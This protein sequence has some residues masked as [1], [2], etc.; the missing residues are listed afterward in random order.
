MNANRSP[1][2]ELRRNLLTVV[3][4]QRRLVVEQIELR[5]RA[6]HEQIDD[7]L[8]LRRK[9]RR[10]RREGPSRGCANSLSSSSADSASPPMPK[11]DC[12]KKCR[13]VMARRIVGCICIPWSPFRRGSTARSRRASRPPARA[14]SMSFDRIALDDTCR[15]GRGRLGTVRAA[16]GMTRRSVRPL[17][18]AGGRV[19]DEPEGER[20][21]ASIEGP[22]PRAATRAASA[23]A[24]SKI[25]FV[26]QAS[27]APAAACSCAR[28]GPCSAR[29]SS[30]RTS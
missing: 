27:S 22:A 30:H 14:A 5:R 9:V 16:A 13:R 11:P 10:L 2:N 25:R 24:A 6:G 18:V 4:L 8:G 7:V 3:L 23:L 20:D 26:V 29:G 17:P 15:R 12:L 28:A 21:R 19:S 1:W